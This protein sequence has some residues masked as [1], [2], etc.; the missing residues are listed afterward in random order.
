MSKVEGVKSMFKTIEALYDNGRITV[1]NDEIKVKKAKVLITIIEEEKPLKS[2]M[3]ATA[4]FKLSGI[5]KSF[6][7]DPVKYQR[8]I[9]E[10]W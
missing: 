2:G 5:L 3:K 4:L 1:I 7:E 6:K 9:R 8:R 10:E